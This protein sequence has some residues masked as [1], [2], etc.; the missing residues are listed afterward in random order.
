[1]A[2][3]LQL[4][5][6]EYHQAKA[7]VTRCSDEL[8]QHLKRVL[9]S[10]AATQPTVR[11]CRVYLTALRAMRSSCMNIQLALCTL[12]LVFAGVLLA[13]SPIASYAIESCPPFSLVRR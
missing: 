8:W 7:E 5:Q 12:F 11:E 13:W 9:S 1:M 2:A 4:T 3:S 6:E 10:L